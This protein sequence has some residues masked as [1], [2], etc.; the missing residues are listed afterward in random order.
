[1][2]QIAYFHE[3]FPYLLPIEKASLK[4][5]KKNSVPCGC[6]FEIV[7]RKLNFYTVPEG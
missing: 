3:Y 5:K 4:K 1:M 2:K 6:L 7:V